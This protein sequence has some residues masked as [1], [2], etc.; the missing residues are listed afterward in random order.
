MKRLAS[1]LPN[2]YQQDLK[3]SYF[4]LQIWGGQFVSEEPEFCQV[5]QWIAAGDWVIDIGANIGHYTFCFANLVG[6]SGRVIA[7]EPVPE[8]FELLANNVAF[9]PFRNVT[10]L[11]IAASDTPQIRGMTVPTYETGLANYYE[12]HLTRKDPAFRVLCTPLDSL[13][14]DHPIK[15]VKIDAEGHE[16]C[17][18]RGM[19]TL[20]ERDHPVLVVE[21]GT[22][23]V[24]AFLRDYGYHFEKTAGSPNLVCHC[25]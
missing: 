20:L 25:Q 15:L 18:L 7:V 6:A 14:L 21:C 19:Q 11:N 8:T 2:R 17:V 9:L 12:A 24:T 22:P 23:E 13:H 5:G 1:R 3:R 10:L 4:A 16:L